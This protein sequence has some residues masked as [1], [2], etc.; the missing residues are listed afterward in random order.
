MTT[1]T[2]RWIDPAQMERAIDELAEFGARGETGVA[3][4]VYSPEWT[5]AQDQAAAWMAEAGL[6]V[7]RDAVGNIWGYQDGTADGGVIA[8]GSHIDSQNPGGRFDGALGVVGG[9]AALRVLKERFG[10]PQKTLAVV[11][12]AEEEASR[13]AAA[14]FWG[15]RAIVGRIPP[16]DPRRLRGYDGVTMA[17]AMRDAGFDPHDIPAAKRNDID[18]FIELHIEQGPYLEQAGL[19]VGIVERITGLRHYHVTL[20]GSANHAGTTPMDMRRDAMAGAAEIISGVVNT[21][22]RMGRPVVTTVGRMHITP[23]ERAVIPQ[24][25]TF[26]VDARSPDPAQRD[27]LLARHEALMHDVSAR[28][29]LGLTIR[30]DSDRVPV[31]SDPE[32]VAAIAAAADEAGIP[33][34]RMASGAVHDAMQLAE[35]ARVAMIFARSRRGISHSPEEYTS[36]EDAAAATEVLARTL[37]RLGYGA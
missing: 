6:R 37:Y 10:Q 7:E 15:S 21:A 8:T 18:A 35:I 5:A 22:H 36:P 26:T 28:R 29:G 33:A 13:F 4:L 16:D 2:E 11:S 1:A 34:Q 14:N 27:Q 31:A 23:N 3:R 17:E 19:P 30:V 25:V 9:I 12:L 20:E 24:Q 32:L